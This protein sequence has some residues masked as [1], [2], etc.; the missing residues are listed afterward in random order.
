MLN[1]LIFFTGLLFL[2][3]CGL[4]VPERDTNLPAPT[5]WDITQNSAPTGTAP[6]VSTNSP[7][8]SPSA[9]AESPVPLAAPPAATNSSES[10][11]DYPATWVW[12]NQWAKRRGI[13][14]AEQLALPPL[15][16]E[17]TNGYKWQNAALQ[18]RL[19]LIP[20]PTFL[21]HTTNG[22][23]MLQPGTRIAH[24]DRTEIRLGFPS[25]LVQGQMLVHALDL[26]RTIEPLLRGCP[27]R[28]AGGRTIVLDPD[29]EAG[30]DKIPDSLRVENYALDWARRLA[31][32]LETNGWT[33]FLTHTNDLL[34]PLNQRMAMAD[35]HHPDLFLHLCFGLGESGSARPGLATLCFT[36]AN[37]PDDTASSESGDLWRTYPNNRFDA[38]NWQFAY[39]LHRALAGLPNATD[40]GLRRSRSLEILRDRNYPAVCVSGGSLADPRDAALIASPLF[41]QQLAEAVA[42]ALP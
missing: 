19:A 36:P 42:R 3:G 38:E 39:C 10:E 13:P 34:V 41:R 12:L 4:F 30:N 15:E 7:P 17:I 24:W 21:L 9:P 31:P 33:V 23:L 37:M 11:A 28:P 1:R 40:H 14:P 22:V 26:S 27:V 29:D 16:M 2:T 6:A 32:L 35:V 20:L 8:V 18:A 5:N 25:E